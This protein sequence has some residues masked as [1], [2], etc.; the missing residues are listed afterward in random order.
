MKSGVQ[1]T[2]VW[3]VAAKTRV[4]F[5]SPV[6]RS[7]DVELLRKIVS[8]LRDAERVAEVAAK[9]L[10]RHIER[11]LTTFDEFRVLDCELSR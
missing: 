8:L 3:Y 6:S 5:T 11:P 2:S 4:S 9:N 7:Y 1:S 10:E